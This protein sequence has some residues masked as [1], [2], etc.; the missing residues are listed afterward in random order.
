MSGRVP[1]LDGLRSIAILC[2][3]AYH[4][5]YMLGGWLGVDV[6]FVL[7]GYL[8]TSIL[9][10]ET[11]KFGCFSFSQFYVRRALRLFPA[12]LLFLAIYALSAT[13]SSRREEH[14]I[15]A[16]WAAVYLMNW[17][18][19]FQF[20][21]AEYLGHTWTLGA[22]EQFYL[23]WPPILALVVLPLRRCRAPV[24]LS[25]IVACAV[26]RMWLALHEVDPNRTAHGFDTRAD[27]LLIGCMLAISFRS[28]PLEIGQFWIVPATVLAYI[29]VTTPPNEVWL[30]LGG[31]TLI[32]VC[33][34]WII[35][36]LIGKKDNWLKIALRTRI[37]TSIG[38]IS[39]SFYLWHAPIIRALYHRG[40]S[41]HSIAL[42]ALLASL[43]LATGSY[44]LI[45][46]LFIR[47]KVQRYSPSTV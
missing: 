35:F 43:A 40:F 28:I 39:Y 33:A 38:L 12:F 13:F 16:R 24:V 32:A 46:R 19:A 23:A 5:N 29:A 1:E 45:E 47:I 6:F 17:Y 20:G 25:L 15:E 21:P 10:R 3:F 41:Q 37:A 2:V 34:A 44:F 31:Y 30:P 26:W 27:A 22:E 9:V 42:I 8:I 11:E 4:V 7:S 18:K 14:L 36:S